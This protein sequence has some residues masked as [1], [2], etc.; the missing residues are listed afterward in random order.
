MIAR[1]VDLQ[2]S[3]RQASTRRVCLQNCPRDPLASGRNVRSTLE[4]VNETPHPPVPYCRAP[5]GT[6][7][8]IYCLHGIPLEVPCPSNSGAGC[9]QESSTG[10]HRLSRCPHSTGFRQA[11]CRFSTTATNELDKSHFRQTCSRVHTT[12]VLS[13]YESLGM[14]YGFLGL[15]VLDPRAPFGRAQYTPATHI[16]RFIEESAIVRTV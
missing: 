11:H 6:Y 14:K 16:R 3:Q 5:H 13:V 2:G 15:C 9:Y 8:D 10:P 12:W 7:V 4:F 1:Q